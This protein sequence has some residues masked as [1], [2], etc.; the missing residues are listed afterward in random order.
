MECKKSLLQH[1]VGACKE[2]IVDENVPNIRNGVGFSADIH[3][4]FL[5]INEFSNNCLFS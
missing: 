5:E 1:K 2:M 4:S 3:S